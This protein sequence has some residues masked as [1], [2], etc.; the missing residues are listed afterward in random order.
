MSE[1]RILRCVSLKFQIAAFKK[2]PFVAIPF[3]RHSFPSLYDH[4]PLH[5]LLRLKTILKVT[6]I[7]FHLVLYK[8]MFFNSYTHIDMDF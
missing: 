2:P 1:H 3:I 7:S 5:T 4:V 8:Y 6:F